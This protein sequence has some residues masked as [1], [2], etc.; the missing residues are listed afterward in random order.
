M[1]LQLEANARKNVIRQSR[2]GMDILPLRS[3]AMAKREVENSA[4]GRYFFT[5]LN[6]GWVN[7]DTFRRSTNPV[8]VGVRVPDATLAAN[9]IMLPRRRRGV[10][11]LVSTGRESIWRLGGIPRGVAYYLIAYEVKEGRAVM[12]HRF[13]RN[14]SSDIVELTYEPV[15]KTELRERL[16]AIL[17]R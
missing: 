13:I 16:E 17:S 2:G 1:Y 6:L 15:A 4:L 11:P 3:T 7:C 8:R 12:A 10:L 9:V 5:V 14:A